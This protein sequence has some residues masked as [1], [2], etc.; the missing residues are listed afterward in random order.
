MGMKLGRFR[1]KIK[2]WRGGRVDDGGGLEN[3]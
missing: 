3:R 1:Y 2:E